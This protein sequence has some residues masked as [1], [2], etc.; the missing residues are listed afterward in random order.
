MKRGFVFLGI[1]LMGVTAGGYL[2]S[3]FLHGQGDLPPLSPAPAIPKEMTSYRELVKKVLPAVV[4]I[5]ARTKVVS[6]KGKAP[7][8]LDDFR[9]FFDEFREGPDLPDLPRKG[10]GSGFFIAAKGIIVTNN[11]VVAGADGVT[12]HLHDGRKFPSKEIRS[13]RRTDLAVI[14]L[15]PKAGPFPFLE[16]GDSEAMEIGDRVLAVGAPFGLA[17]TVTHGIISGK[18]RNGLNLTMYEDYL[19]TDAAINPGNS[20]GPLVSL[21]GKVIGINA[22][23]KTKTGGFQGV[24]L[25]IASNMARDVT[26]KLRTFGVVKRG[27]LGT[28]I[29]EL[30]EEVRLRLGVPSDQGVVM[31]E[32]F[33]KTPAAKVGLRPGDIVTAIEGK[34]V[35]DGRAFQMQVAILPLDKPAVLGVFRDGKPINVEVVIEEQ[36]AEFGSATVPLPRVPAVRIESIGVK[37]FD[38]EVADLTDAVAEGLGYRKGASGALVSRVLPGGAAYEAGLR[39]AMI[40]SRVEKDAVTSAAAAR[41]AL[42]SVDPARGALLQVQSPTGGTYYLVLRPGGE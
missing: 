12:V 30:D 34:P 40:I 42:E 7:G 16:L 21:D 32:V 1:F 39:P 37:K 26:D 18:G 2:V 24:G 17:G 9:R 4:S 19:Q 41:T 20:G 36:P 31:S 22:A 33:E 11:H 5:E 38:M 8:S 27:Y 25:A 13:D 6:G 23:I 3:N 10:F 35:K 15:D 28:Q 29:R 14:Y